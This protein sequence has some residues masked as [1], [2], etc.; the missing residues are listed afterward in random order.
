MTASMRRPDS[1]VWKV[2]KDGHLIRPEYHYTVAQ[3]E[4]VRVMVPLTPSHSNSTKYEHPVSLPFVALQ[5]A[6]TQYL[7]DALAARVRR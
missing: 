6:S 7:D 2:G 5:Y 3:S 4:K 1:I